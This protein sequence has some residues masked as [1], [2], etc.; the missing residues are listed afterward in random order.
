MKI[1]GEDREG[2]G[3]GEGWEVGWGKRMGINWYIGVRMSPIPSLTPWL[4]DTG[5]R[6]IGD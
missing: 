4:V 2:E 6:V 1:R 5:Q 3:W